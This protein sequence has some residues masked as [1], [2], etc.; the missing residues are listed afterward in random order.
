LIVYAQKEREIKDA[1]NFLSNYDIELVLAGGYD[2]LKVKE[3][4]KEKNIPVIITGLFRTP[5]RDYE[6]FDRVFSLPYKLWKEGIKFC[7][8]GSGSPFSAV[9]ER[10]LPYYASYAMRYGLPEEEALKSITLYV[11][12]ILGVSDRIGSI[13]EGK[14]ASFVVTDGDIFDIRTNVLM[15]FIKGRKIDLSNRQKKL[16]EKYKNKYIR[17]KLI[18][19]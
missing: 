2:A 1:I 3:L 8:A 18:D 11:A 9:N 4:L 19:K 6:G 16:Y 15:A 13:S 7:I 14:D 17:K 5:M 10:N 12:E